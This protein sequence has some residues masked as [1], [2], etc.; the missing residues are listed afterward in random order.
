VDQQTYDIIGAA[1]EVHCSLGSGFLEA[2]YKEAFSI[3]LAARGIPFSGEPEIPVYY[4]GKRLK[5]CYRSDFICHDSIIVEL[6][7][8]SKLGDLEMAQ[9]LN[10][11]RATGFHKGLLFNFGAKKPRETKA[12]NVTRVPHPPPTQSTTLISN[13]ICAIR[14]IC[15]LKT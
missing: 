8:I 15:G 1:L 12:R 9:V 13:P 5:T 6:K 7:A 2:A 3:E 4:K 10:Y 14:V 11:L